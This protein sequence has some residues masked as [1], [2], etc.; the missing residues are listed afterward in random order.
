MNGAKRWFDNHC[1]FEIDSNDIFKTLDILLRYSRSQF[2]SPFK[3]EQED[4]KESE[5]GFLIILHSFSLFLD[6][7]A[8]ASAA[9]GGSA[10]SKSKDK[11]DKFY[12]DDDEEPNEVLIIIIN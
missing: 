11:K 6:H 1:V 4:S 7:L 8:S 9:T 10:K 3:S 12:S 2:L 5:E